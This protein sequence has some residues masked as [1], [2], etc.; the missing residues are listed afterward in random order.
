[1]FKQESKIIQFTF[2][3][4]ETAP[5]RTDYKRFKEKQCRPDEGALKLFDY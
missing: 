4:N 5:W 3:F 2:F 1:M